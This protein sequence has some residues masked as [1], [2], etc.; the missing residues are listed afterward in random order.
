M[1]PNLNRIR[2][3]AVNKITESLFL[4][5]VLTVFIMLNT[6]STDALENGRQRI[7]NANKAK[8]KNTDCPDESLKSKTPL[9][10]SME[11]SGIFP[12]KW[13]RKLTKIS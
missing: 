3:M 13:I 10:N 2:M 8:F 4:A 12:L 11:L 6:R 5:F 9:Q 7:L 1:V